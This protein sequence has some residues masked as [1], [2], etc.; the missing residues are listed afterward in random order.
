M[1]VCTGSSHSLCLCLNTVSTVANASHFQLHCCVEW[2]SH[3]CDRGVCLCCCLAPSPTADIHVHTS[4]LHSRSFRHRAELLRICHSMVNGL[5]TMHVF[6]CRSGSHGC[7]LPL[8]RSSRSSSPTASRH[9]RG[10][11]RRT[12]AMSTTT[13]SMTMRRSMA[14]STRSAPRLRW[15]L[16]RLREMMLSALASSRPSSRY[17]STSLRCLACTHSSPP[18]VNPTALILVPTSTPPH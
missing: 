14:T 16:S 2:C 1:L 5:L 8:K 11:T 4:L 13:R 3:Y 7:C 10:S 18:P 12:R 6:W 17:T 15:M 9:L